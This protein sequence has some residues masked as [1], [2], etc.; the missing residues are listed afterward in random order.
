[1]VEHAYARGHGI[2]IF[3]TLVG[4]KEW[5]LQRLQ[6]LH[7]SVFMVHVF[8]D[9]AYMNSYAR[10]ENA[11]SVWARMNALDTLRSKDYAFALAAFKPTIEAPRMWHPQ[12]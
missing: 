2:R 10:R 12:R 5:D 7:V 1:M 6:A 4:M 8:D 9:G 3:T 11:E